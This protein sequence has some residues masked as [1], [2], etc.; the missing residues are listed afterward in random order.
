[1]REFPLLSG[2][3]P[4]APRDYAKFWITPRKRSLVFNQYCACA[5]NEICAA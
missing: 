5:Q 1:M 4:I 2:K 3:A